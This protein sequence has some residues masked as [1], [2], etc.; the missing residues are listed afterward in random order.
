MKNMKVRCTVCNVEEVLDKDTLK[1]LSNMVK[2]YKLSADSYTYLL[3]KMRG[4]C[5]DTDEHSFVFDEE[6][7]KQMTEIVTKYKTNINEGTILE[8][9]NIQLKKEADELVIKIDELQ[10]KRNSN[11]KRLK[12]INEDTKLLLE[13]L[14][15]S[16]T[17]NSNIE[18]WE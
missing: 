8:T 14:E 12:T 16:L 2:K 3:N 9:T 11:L 7:T 13:E 17:G 10:S 18:I 6:F 5:I 4:K 15:E 1:D